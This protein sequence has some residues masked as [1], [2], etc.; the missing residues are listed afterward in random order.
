[1]TAAHDDQHM[2]ARTARG[3][4][5]AA[6]TLALSIAL[7]GIGTGVVVHRR[8]PTSAAEGT[9]GAGWRA[10]PATGTIGPG[11]AII[12]TS[13]Q[14]ATTTVVPE[15]TTTVT[16][17]PVKRVLADLP[18]VAIGSI[19]ARVSAFG[20]SVMLEAE[21]ELAAAVSDLSLDAVIGR[22]SAATLEAARAF[23]D[24]GRL[25]DEIVLQVG[26]NGTVTNDEIDQFM[27]LFADA[28]RVL[29]VNLKVDREWEAR[30]NELLADRVANWPNAVLVDWNSLAST[31]PEGLLS[32][33]VHLQPAGVDLYSRLILSG[34]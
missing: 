24:A 13:P 20:D 31:D 15:T 29:V 28:S 16:T 34:L 33:G 30:N 22:Q 6:W 7:V 4:R 10:V 18:P 3:A 27:S 8:T 17:K 25:G 23:H 14:A 32:D 12:A 5:A 2:T 1:M 26:N 19:N 21:S 9:G 11:P